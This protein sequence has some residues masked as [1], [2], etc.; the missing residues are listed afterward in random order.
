MAK[1]RGFAGALRFTIPCPN[2]DSQLICR[3]SSRLNSTVR[4]SYS[5]CPNIACGA[6]F[7]AI[8]EVVKMIM[9]PRVATGQKLP[10][11]AN[12]EDIN[13]MVETVEHQQDKLI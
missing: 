4:I 10:L 5:Q 6:S 3:T 13:K 8:T 7:Q 2:C 9:P 11:C 12:D 1:I